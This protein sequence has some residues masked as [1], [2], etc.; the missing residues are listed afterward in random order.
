MEFATPEFRELLSTFN[1]HGVNYL[2]V[3]GFAVMEFT[4]PR[5]TK[6]LKVMAKI[7]FL[8]VVLLLV[9]GRLSAQSSFPFV[10][11]FVEPPF[12]PA[13]RAVRAEGDVIVLVEVNAEGNVIKAAATTG[14]PLL[15]TAAVDTA[16]KWEF[17]RV[18]GTHYV[19]L[20]FR[21]R[22]P[23]S[24]KW[25]PA[26]LIGHFT[27]DVIEPRYQILQTVSPFKSSSGQ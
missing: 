24:G 25:K 21:F 7:I 3:G 4:E 2:I 23:D 16:K 17:S 15:R 12:P 11:R 5:F 18:P 10:I 19:N 6:D 22:I 1:A 14:H 8:L 9:A 27:L 26:Q 13:A 20:I